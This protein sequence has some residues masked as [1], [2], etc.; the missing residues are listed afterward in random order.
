MNKKDWNDAEF[1]AK[2][3]LAQYKSIGSEGFLGTSMIQH[4]LERY[5][6]GERTLKLYNEMNELE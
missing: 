5:D 2:E 4:I 3:L 1:H 6:S